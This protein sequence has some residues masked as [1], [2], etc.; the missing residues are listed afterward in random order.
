[1]F[2]KPLP[3]ICP[4][5]A[6]SQHRIGIA[7]RGHLTTSK[8]CIYNRSLQDGII[9]RRRI[10]NNEKED[11]LRNLNDSAGRNAVR[12]LRPAASRVLRLLHRD[13]WIFANSSTGGDQ[14]RMYPEEKQ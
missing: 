4:P 12:R 2:F 6:G 1:M 9:I 5:A 14:L 13:I 8:R 11:L 10:G 7:G 3:T